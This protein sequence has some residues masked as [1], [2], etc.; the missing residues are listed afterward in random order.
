LVEAAVL[1]LH[2]TLAELERPTPEAAGAVFITLV[3]QDL[4]AQEGVVPEAPMEQ[5]DRPEAATLVAVAV[6]AGQMVEI[7]QMEATAALALLLFPTLALRN[8]LLAAH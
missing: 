1:G 7:Y 3:Q 5:Q 4:E 8:G 2:L 6:V